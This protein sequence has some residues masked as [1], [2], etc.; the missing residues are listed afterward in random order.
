MASSG[1]RQEPSYASRALPSDPNS[2]PLL[3]H[4]QAIRQAHICHAVAYEHAETLVD[5]LFRRTGD[6][7]SETMTREGAQF[8]ARIM[9]EEKGWSPARVEAEAR[10]YLDHIGH[11]HGA[12]ARP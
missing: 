11:L 12:G 2:E 7:W 9:G 3:N 1:P 5:V 4:D 10:R 8:A 6:G